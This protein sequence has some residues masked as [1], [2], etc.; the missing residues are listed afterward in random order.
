MATVQEARVV[1][2][3]V[4]VAANT[5][6]DFAHRMENLPLWASGLATGI[7]QRDGQ[8][9]TDSPMG[10]VRVDMAPH[11]PFGVLDHDVTLP[12]GTTVHNAFRVTPCGGHGSLLSFVVLRFEGVGQAN[13]E[14]DVAHVRKD[15]AALQQLLER[16]AS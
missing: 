1:S 15:L 16:Q 10:K 12:D 6:Y 4:A 5:V 14:A 13:F 8:W 11:N 9:F 2:Q 7:E 3:S